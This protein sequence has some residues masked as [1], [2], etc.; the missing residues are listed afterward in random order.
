MT[1]YE[2]LGVPSTASIDDIKSAY[3][4]LARQFHPDRWRGAPAWE[5]KRAA[6][7]FQGIQEAYKALI[8]NR[9]DYD[10]EPQAEAEE[11][12]AP[13][14]I[15]TA[16]NGAPAPI[17]DLASTPPM[18]PEPETGN[19]SR[20]A[21]SIH[22]SPRQAYYYF[23]L[24]LLIFARYMIYSAIR[25]PLKQLDQERANAAAVEI[26]APRPQQFE[27][28]MSDAAGKASAV[29]D[30]AFQNAY[31]KLSG[32][33]AVKPPFSG[34][35]ELAGRVWGSWF[36]FTVKTQKEKYSF[37]GT[38]DGHDIG[39]SYTLDRKDG[40]Q[41][42]GSFSLVQVASEADSESLPAE[43]CPADTP[44]HMP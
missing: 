8:R 38:R 32:C 15:Q 23:G 9:P 34:S 12:P 26:R 2:I 44:A 13:S 25:D 1:Y 16:A 4:N 33:M 41:E 42:S 20:I 6:Q 21:N 7:K 40:P 43:N 3:R 31:G 17:P 5:V 11:V 18:S 24:A 28:T 27:G 10:K 37:S 19:W 22:I 39:G 29:F 30:I 35:G 14:V 36:R